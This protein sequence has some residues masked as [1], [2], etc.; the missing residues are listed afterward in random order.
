MGHDTSEHDTTYAPLSSSKKSVTMPKP[1]PLPVDCSGNAG[2]APGQK[3][4]ARIEMTDELK[5]SANPF[6][7][8]PGDWYH[9]S[10]L[11]SHSCSHNNNNYNNNNNNKDIR[12]QRRM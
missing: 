5:S 8:T 4:S 10:P 9:G 3:Q 7:P 12:V 11:R 2:T 6:D 1:P